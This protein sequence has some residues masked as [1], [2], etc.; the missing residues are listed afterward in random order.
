VRS[1]AEA[2]A[3]PEEQAVKGQCFRLFDFGE[4]RLSGLLTDALK[5]EQVGLGVPR[6]D[7]GSL[8]ICPPMAQ[9]QTRN[10]DIVSRARRIWLCT[11]C[12]GNS[13]RLFAD[14][15]ARCL[16]KRVYRYGVG[17]SSEAHSGDA[18]LC[19]STYVYALADHDIDRQG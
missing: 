15:F 9:N 2:N 12:L 14:R 4:E 8:P 5:G 19:E 11:H 10:T 13:I 17:V 3:K 16:L 1:N 6:F 18:S 7:L